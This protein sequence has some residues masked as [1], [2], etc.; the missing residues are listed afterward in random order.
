MKLLQTC[1]LL[2][3]LAGSASAEQIGL[4]RRRKETQDKMVEGRLVPGCTTGECKECVTDECKKDNL[5][6]DAVAANNLAEVR[7]AVEGGRNIDA[8][9]TREGDL[10]DVGSRVLTFH[11]LYHQYS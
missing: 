11:I 6:F 1:V 4:G 10:F 5:F 7:K 2:L 8:K 9:D 3:A